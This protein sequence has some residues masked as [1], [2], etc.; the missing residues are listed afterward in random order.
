MIVLI[1]VNRGRGGSRTRRLSLAYQA[2]EAC[3]DEPAVLPGGGPT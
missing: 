1:L 3:E 2:L